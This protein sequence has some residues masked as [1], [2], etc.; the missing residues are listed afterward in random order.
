MDRGLAAA[1]AGARR[2]DT[3]RNDL[4]QLAAMLAAA[5][6]GKLDAEQAMVPAPLH[7]A[8]EQRPV[9]RPRPAA[10]FLFALR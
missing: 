10:T 3:L 4:D 2:A 5:R 6:I 1:T 9:S 8:L 7:R